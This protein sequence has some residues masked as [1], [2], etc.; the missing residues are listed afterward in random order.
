MD[1]FDPFGNRCPYS[2]GRLNLSGAIFDRVSI[3][4]LLGGFSLAA[5]AIALVVTISVRLLSFPARHSREAQRNRRALASGYMGRAD[6]IEVRRSVA[7][8]VGFV[9]DGPGPSEE[10]NPLMHRCTSR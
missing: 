2:V 10:G 5:Y 7:Q 8:R 6:W 3:F 9:L 4:S 1:R